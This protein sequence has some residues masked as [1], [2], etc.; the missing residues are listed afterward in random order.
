[1][2]YCFC[3]VV[4]MLLFVSVVVYVVLCIVVIFEDILFVEFID[5]YG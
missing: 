3:W 1:M 2:F 5:G 4:G